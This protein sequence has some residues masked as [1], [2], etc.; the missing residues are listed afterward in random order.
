MKYKAPE[1]IAEDFR[2]LMSTIEV[3]SQELKNSTSNAKI[4]ELVDEY[5][6]CAGQFPAFDGLMF[7]LKKLIEV[8]K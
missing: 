1:Q 3:Q 8:S 4:Q 2:L 6:G 5:K 7:K